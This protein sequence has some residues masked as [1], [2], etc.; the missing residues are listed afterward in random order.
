MQ[1][2]DRFRGSVLGLAAG[3]AAGTT[4]EFEQ[5]GSFREITDMVGGGPFNLKRGEWTDDTSMM[6]CLG[7]SLV[8][9]RGF[10]PMDQM[11]RYIRWYRTGYMSSNGRCFDIGT[12]VRQALHQFER[13]SKP[14]CGST[15]PNT[16]GNGSLMRLAPVPLFFVNDPAAAIENAALSSRTTH[17][18]AVAVDACRYMA[19]LIV[20]AIR[21]ATKEE[22]LTDHFSPFPGCWENNP[23]CPEIAAIARGSYK[24]NQPPKI[25]GT[26][27]AAAS[28]EAALWA[29]YND[30]SF[31]EGCLKAANLGND[32]DTT[33]AIYGQLAGAF[34]GVEGIPEKWRKQL[35][36]LAELEELADQLLAQSF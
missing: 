36:K 5:P 9:C 30:K 32:A 17:G 7:A 2:R 20:G 12:T 8:A 15:E 10:D 22:L 11:Q 25:K 31:K 6:M 13:T 4:L 28:L 27:Y 23:L 1:L 35:A 3:D 21:G 33:A 26:G 19:S 16:A 34:Y 24:E 18:A 29:F 14:Y